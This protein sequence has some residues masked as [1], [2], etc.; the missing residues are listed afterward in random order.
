MPRFG[1][2]TRRELIQSFR[3]AGF[4]GPAPGTKHRVMVKGEHR[5]VIPNPHGEDIGIGLLGRILKEAGIPR[6]DWEKL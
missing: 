4:V 2:I 1:P 3:K 5:V 6:S